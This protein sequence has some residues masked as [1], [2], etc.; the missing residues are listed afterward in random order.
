MNFYKKKQT[1][2]NE[3]KELNKK[4]QIINED[5]LT[6]NEK[7]ERIENTKNNLKEEIMGLG[8]MELIEKEKIQS[9]KQKI[10]DNTEAFVIKTITWSLI[11][12]NRQ[13][14][15]GSAFGINQPCS[16]EEVANIWARAFGFNRVVSWESEMNKQANQPLYYLPRKNSS[17]KE[18][19]WYTSWNTSATY[20]VV[21]NIIAIM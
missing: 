9:M 16:P 5:L 6:L 21:R 1:V 11:T 18:A 7:K 8:I 12:D 15:L 4:L 14:P 13:E 19:I 10:K 17:L 3:L 2:E 20:P